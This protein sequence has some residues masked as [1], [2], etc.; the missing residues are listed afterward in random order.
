MRPEKSTSGP[1]VQIG[2]APAASGTIAEFLPGDRD[3]AREGLDDMGLQGVWSGMTLVAV[4]GRPASTWRPI[5]T[6]RRR[7]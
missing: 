1:G 7:R 2:V 4:D 5:R 3:L 6:C